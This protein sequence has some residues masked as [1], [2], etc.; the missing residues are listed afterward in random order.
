MTR[1]KLTTKKNIPEFL[2]SCNLIEIDVFWQCL[3]QDKGTD[4]EIK[5]INNSYTLLKSLKNE[6]LLILVGNTYQHP[7]KYWFALEYRFRNVLCNLQKSPH[8]VSISNEQVR[9]ATK[10]LKEPNMIGVFTDKKVQ[11]WLDYCEECYEKIKS[12]VSEIKERNEL[13]KKTIRDT[14]DS[15]T[16]KRVSG[17]H[18]GTRYNIK[19]GLFEIEFELIIQEAYLSKKVRFNGTVEDAVKLSNISIK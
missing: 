10:D 12:A 18:N 9:S 4:R 15:L 11:H 3:I 8:W 6:I 17:W 7:N 13:H 19:S 2:L 14:I 16:E 5:Y 1:V